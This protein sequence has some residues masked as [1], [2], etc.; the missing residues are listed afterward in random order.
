MKSNKSRY[1]PQALQTALRTSLAAGCNWHYTREH[2]STTIYFSLRS[3]SLDEVLHFALHTVPA[4][5]DLEVSCICARDG[6]LSRF[7]QEIAGK[8]SKKE[9]KIVDFEK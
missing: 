5:T 9:Y 3:K 6:K 7:F 2:L 4:D 1:Y 8:M